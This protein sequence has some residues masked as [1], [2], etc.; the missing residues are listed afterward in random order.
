MLTAFI[1]FIVLIMAVSIVHEVG[2]FIAAKLVGARV[3]VFSIG[4]G[5]GVSMKVGQTRYKLSVIPAGGYVHLPGMTFSG[6]QQD[7]HHDNLLHKSWWKRAFVF[8]AGFIANFL[9]GIL[10]FMLAMNVNQGIDDSTTRQSSVRQATSYVSATVKSTADMANSIQSKEE[11]PAIYS[12]TEL[13]TVSKLFWNAG[14]QSYLE[15]LGIVSI[16]LGTFNMIPIPGLDGSWVLASAYEGIR[17]EYIKVD[18]GRKFGIIALTLMV[19]M[20]VGLLL[21]DIYKLFIL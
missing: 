7:A 12:W 15:F 21:V 11:A 16:V 9:F 20:T 14:W 8:S 1:S 6:D 18:Y 10:C 5:P 17:G 19:V 2:H 3:D 4:F 13:A